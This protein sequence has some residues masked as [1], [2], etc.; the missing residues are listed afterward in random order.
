MHEQTLN[1]YVPGHLPAVLPPWLGMAIV[2][3]AA[4][5]YF[6]PGIDLS[7]SRLFT[8]PDHTFPLQ[9]DVFLLGVNR[10]VNRLSLVFA[11]G[12]TLATLLAWIP[13]AVRLG[14][15]A[16]LARRRTVLAFLFLAM[17]LGPG[18]L[19]NTMLK[20]HWGRAR[21]SDIAEFGGQRQFTRAFV[22]SHECSHNCAFVS[23]HAAVAA[24]PLAGFFIART[25][26]A[27]RAWL[28]GGILSGLAV[29]LAR[30]LTGSHFLSD[31]VI[32]VLLT[33]VVCALCAAWLLRLR[34][35][36]GGARPA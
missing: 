9:H 27:R 8:T 21:P 17:S 36:R 19:V 24:M 22:L 15:L 23:G 10:V 32:A 35:W 30:M 2:V 6:L 20:E 13:R 33:Y 3:T 18:L 16:P 25:R 12:L 34:P 4:V 31:V 26:R 14:A 7:A 29:G 28:A 11:A 5:F 1:R